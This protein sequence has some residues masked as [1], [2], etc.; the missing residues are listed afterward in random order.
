M[1]VFVSDVRYSK[2]FCEIRAEIYPGNYPASALLTV[3]GFA[4]PEIMVEISSIAVAG[5]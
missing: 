3:A 5:A 1:T 2:R 4:V